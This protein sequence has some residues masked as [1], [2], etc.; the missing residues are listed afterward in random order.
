LSPAPHAV[1]QDVGLLSDPQDDPQAVP[2]FLSS[3]AHPL[4]ITTSPPLHN[5]GILI[6]I[7]SL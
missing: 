3:S 1:P 5:F 7:Y 4:S 6:P 2:L